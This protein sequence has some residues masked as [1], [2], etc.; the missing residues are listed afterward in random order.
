LFNGFGDHVDFIDRDAL[1]TNVTLYWLTNT[2]ESSTRLYYENAHNH[3]QAPQGPN[4]IP[5]G[6]AVFGHDFKSMKCFAKRDNTNIVQ[7]SEF[8][9]GTHFAAMDAPDLLAPDIQA[10]F[11][12]YR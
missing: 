10:F 7:W 1:L 8:E 2:A 9:R 4:T 6:V 5:T 12:R 3:E 11:R